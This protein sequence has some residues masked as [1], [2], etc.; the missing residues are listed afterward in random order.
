MDG[1]IGN[2][3]RIVNSFL[4]KRSGCTVNIVMHL[5]LDISLNLISYWMCALFADLGKR[6]DL[7]VAPKSVFHIMNLS[8]LATSLSFTMTR[9]RKGAYKNE[10]T[11]WTD[12]NN[13]WWDGQTLHFEK[14]VSWSFPSPFLVSRNISQELEKLQS[15]NKKII[16]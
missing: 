5:I 16:S 6:K 12:T 4:N 11:H 8:L 9:K 2:M 7:I 1:N 3:G 14:V 10:H 13:T 15:D